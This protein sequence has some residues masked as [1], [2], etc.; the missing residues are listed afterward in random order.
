LKLFKNCILRLF[1]IAQLFS[2]S[3]MYAIN[4][5][6]S[7]KTTKKRCQLFRDGCK[8]KCCQNIQ[9]CTN[10]EI[11][12][13][14]KKSTTEIINQI[15][16]STNQLLAILNIINDNIIKINPAAACQTKFLYQKDFDPIYTVTSS[17]KF[18]LC[19]AIEYSE[20]TGSALVIDASDV[21]L[22]LNGFSLTY[23]GAGSDTNGILVDNEQNVSITN[24]STNN[25]A[26]RKFTG[27][28]IKAATV[29]HLAIN[30]IVANQNR[31]GINVDDATDVIILDCQANSNTSTTASVYGLYINDSIGVNIS[32]CTTSFNNSIGG[33]VA[34]IRL[35]GTTNDSKIFDSTINKNTSST[36]AYGIFVESTATQNTIQSNSLNNNQDFGI[37]DSATNSTNLYTKNI[38]FSNGTSYSVNYTNGELKIVQTYPGALESLINLNQFENI[39]VL[40]TP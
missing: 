18:R 3:N 37:F 4:C 23:T 38:A 36:T 30:N 12:D 33:V 17:G 28:G 16:T 14:I 11:I 22:D 27:S 7:S 21:I 9:D 19:E 39:E 29:D 15:Q 20:A 40:D 24:T 1:I 31:I 8:P 5:K 25:G 13:E 6:S 2:T 32:N 34:G 35:N 26:V 10:C